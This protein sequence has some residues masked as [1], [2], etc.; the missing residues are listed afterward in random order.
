MEGEGKR[1]W[2]PAIFVL[3]PHGDVIEGV[4]PQ[5]LQVYSGVTSFHHEKTQKRY[6]FALQNVSYVP[7]KQKGRIKLKR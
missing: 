6:I 4:V 2:T 7:T 5:P 3:G 1:E